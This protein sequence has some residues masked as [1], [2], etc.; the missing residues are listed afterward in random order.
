[1]IFHCL[2][3]THPIWWQW[4]LPAISGR[5]HVCLFFHGQRLVYCSVPW[6]Y[7]TRTETKHWFCQLYSLSSNLELEVQIWWMVGS[8]K[9]SFGTWRS[10]R[11]YNRQIILQISTIQRNTI[12]RWLTG[13]TGK[14][15]IC[16]S[17][18]EE[19]YK[20]SF[21]QVS[22]Q[23]VLTFDVNYGNLHMFFIF[24]SSLSPFHLPLSL[25]H[26]CTS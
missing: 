15:K 26:C 7:W 12:T 11:N 24:F 8:S 10:K 23:C 13:S 16:A 2:V 22:D 20:L 18:H 21:S 1:M 9:M 17:T 14:E 5:I 19:E 25:L 3:S 4:T 6:W